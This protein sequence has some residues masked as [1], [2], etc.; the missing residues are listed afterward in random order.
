METT[1]LIKCPFGLKNCFANDKYNQCH[2]LKGVTDKQAICKFYKSSEQELKELEQ[3]AKRINYDWPTY[4]DM[5]E[6]I[7]DET[8]DE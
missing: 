2:A 1:R 6:R 3:C 4:R 7:F 5:I 8:A